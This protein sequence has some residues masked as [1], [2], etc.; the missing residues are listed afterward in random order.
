[1]TKEDKVKL[2]GIS[3]NANNYTH[4]NNHP[5]SIIV[6][7]ASNRFVTDAEKVAWN[8]KAEKTTA[9]TSSDGL[10]GKGDKAKLDGIANNAN[11]YT[12]PSSHPASMITQDANNRF[13]TDKGIA[14]V[15]SWESF[16]NLGGKI[17]GEVTVGSNVVIDNPGHNF[18]APNNYGYMGRDTEG[19]PK[20][21]LFMD[22]NN[23][24]NVGYGNRLV[25]LD[26]DN[27]VQGSGYKLY[28]QGFKPTPADIGA[29]PSNH[30][31][32]YLPLTGGTLK[33]EVR[34]DGPA[35]GDYSLKVKG[36]TIE[37]LGEG[38]ALKA[39]YCGPLY[40]YFNSVYNKPAL[41]PDEDGGV[42]LGQHDKRFVDV[43]LSLD[44][45]ASGSMCTKLPNGNILQSGGN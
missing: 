38:I 42:Y 16:K 32:P 22:V 36:R 11:N 1:M 45:K 9:T 6:Q 17:I 20:Y 34:F 14:I 8:N 23:W 4:P 29:S 18:I 5:P 37:A 24:V 31:H 3:D 40:Y 19:A 7:D 21:L 25:K 28:H 39:K 2:N 26:C 35:E 43:L 27:P 12:H 41:I 44:I 13:L 33:G 15:A 10:M 30:S